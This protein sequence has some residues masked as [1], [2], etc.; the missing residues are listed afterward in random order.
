[1]KSNKMKKILIAS[2][3][4]FIIVTTFILLSP[5][6]IKADSGFDSSYDNTN[7]KIVIW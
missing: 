2:I 7:Y 6:G 1:M 3:I 5:I 4:I